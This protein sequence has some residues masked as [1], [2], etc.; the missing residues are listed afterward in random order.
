MDTLLPFI[1]RET[2][3][4][5]NLKSIM[6]NDHVTRFNDILLQIVEILLY[7]LRPSFKL[8]HFLVSSRE[9]LLK[10]Y[11]LRIIQWPSNSV[12][13]WAQVFMQSYPAAGLLKTMWPKAS[14][15]PS[16]V[17]PSPPRL[18]PCP[19]PSSRARAR[20]LHTRRGKYS[21]HSVKSLD[22]R[23]SSPSLL[24]PLCLWQLKV[25]HSWQTFRVKKIY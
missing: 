15:L 4:T 8:F 17:P 18:L 16:P 13:L 5:G 21:R 9:L 3:L 11:I 6:I 23:P 10:L 14:P 7:R 2:E 12:N 25:W 1:L 20:L 24:L 19:S 22:L